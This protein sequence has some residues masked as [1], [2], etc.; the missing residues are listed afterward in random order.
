MAETIGEINPF[1]YR[2]YYY[3]SETGLYYLNSRYYDPVV[4]RFLSIDDESLILTSPDG[5]TDKNLFSYCDN[6]PIIRI[7]TEGEFWDT[8]FDVVSLVVSVAEVVTNPTSGAAWAGLAADIVCTVVPGLTGGGTIVRTVTKADDVVDTAKAIYKAADKTSDIRRA[9]GSYEI[10]YKSGKNYVGKGGYN[11]AIQ[12]AQRNAQ[13]HSDSVVSISW[14]KAPT[15]KDAFI[16]EYKSM[17][18]FGG[19]NNCIIRNTNS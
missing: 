7:D 2:G 18:K 3:D 16:N 8:I 4:G 17:S 14:K 9:T 19:P 6:N 12:S 1:R 5:L 13:R 15:V 11:R 10:V